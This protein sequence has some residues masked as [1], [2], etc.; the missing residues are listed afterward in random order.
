MVEGINDAA[1]AILAYSSPHTCPAYPGIPPPLTFVV[2]LDIYVPV[3]DFLSFSAERTFL[4]GQDLSEFIFL[5]DYKFR[6]S[7]TTF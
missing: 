4:S 1:N 7:L 6:K 2:L 5:L 3:V